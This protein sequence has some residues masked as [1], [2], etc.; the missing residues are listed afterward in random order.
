MKNILEKK[1]Q[2]RSQLAHRRIIKIAEERL[3]AKQVG[4]RTKA[5]R[6]N[7]EFQGEGTAG[8]NNS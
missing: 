2:E 8:K 6:L 4:N 5:R 1:N 3:E 7:S